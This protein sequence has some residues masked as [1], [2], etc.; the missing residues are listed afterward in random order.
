[1]NAKQVA[2]VVGTAILFAIAVALAVDALMPQ[3][4]YEGYCKNQQFNSY[5]EFVG[6]PEVLQN[7]SINYSRYNSIVNECN[8][9]GGMIVYKY[10]ENGCSI[11]DKC[12]MCN[13]EFQDATNKF[14]KNA[15]YIIFITGIAALLAGLM[16]TD[17][18]GPGLMFGGILTSIYSMIRYF[19]DLDKT[20][21]FIVVLA[22]FIII[23]IVGR[24]KLKSNEEKTKVIKR[25]K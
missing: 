23:V 7:C 5:P 2:F 17:V 25:K 24:K 19:S 21:R 3:P 11:P 8:Q 12:D 9:L 15:F 6:K 20:M 22:S 10:D 13:K 4:K 16:I 18:F 1:M 14:N